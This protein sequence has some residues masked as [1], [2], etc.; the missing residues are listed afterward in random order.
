MRDIRATIRDRSRRV[1]ARNFPETVNSG[2]AR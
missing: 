1:V 2:S